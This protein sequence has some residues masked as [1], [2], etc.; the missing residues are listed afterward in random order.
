MGRSVAY[1]RGAVGGDATGRSTAPIS[2]SVPSPARNGACDRRRRR[3]SRVV[4][5]DIMTEPG[6]ALHPIPQAA[7]HVPKRT[8]RLAMVAVRHPRT[9]ASSSSAEA[10]AFAETVASLP[11]YT[12]LCAGESCGLVHDIEPA[13]AIVRE[14]VAGRSGHPRTASL[15]HERRARSAGGAAGP[16]TAGCQMRRAAPD[17]RA[18]CGR[19]LRV[20]HR[21]R[22]FARGNRR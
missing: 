4:V 6:G 7:D 5:P 2:A 9:A 20:L 17:G 3:Q 8:L 12:A 21:P 11:E 22:E 18:G 14:L 10:W 16:G 19:P 15:I 1:A 13:A